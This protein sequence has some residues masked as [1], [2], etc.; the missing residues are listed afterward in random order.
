[1]NVTLCV[2]RVEFDAEKCSLRLLGKNS[3]ENKYIKMG[4]YHTIDLDVGKAFTIRKTCWDKMFLESLADA[5]EPM[6]K[7]EIAAVVMQEG[8]AHVCLVKSALTVTKARIVRR[9]AKKK[10]V[11]I[12]MHVCSY[13]Y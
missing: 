11:L 10:Q 8:L 2:E 1:M 9:I 13:V 3:E 4:Q 12:C 5:A 7:A 6:R